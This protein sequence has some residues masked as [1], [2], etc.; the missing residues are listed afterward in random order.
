MELVARELKALG[1]YAA[2]SLSFEGVEY[3]PLAHD[4]TEDDIA[5]W[6]AW[7]DAFQLIHANLGEALKATGFNDEEGKAKSGLAA[8]AVHSAF[9]GAKLRFFGQYERI[10]S[11]FYGTEFASSGLPQG[12]GRDADRDEAEKRHDDT[13]L[14]AKADPHLSNRKCHP[15]TAIRYAST[16]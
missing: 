4:L 2:R 5:I 14:V 10:N 3:E 1:L 13:E 12:E 11:Y 8:S 15:R 16:D 7:A 9:E 6:D